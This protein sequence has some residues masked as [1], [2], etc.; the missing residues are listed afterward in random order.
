MT[1][2]I[3]VGE[4][5]IDIDAVQTAI[6]TFENAWRALAGALHEIGYANG[7]FAVSLHCNG[8][9]DNI[10]KM[11]PKI[12]MYQYHYA[13][14]QSSHNVDG[15]NFQ[16]VAEELLRQLIRDRQLKQITMQ[17]GGEE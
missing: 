10:E 16:E 3:R 12:T 8:R 7:D 6:N 14:S 2:L 4:A 15:F 5:K 1:K 11:L 13:K 17:K 9:L